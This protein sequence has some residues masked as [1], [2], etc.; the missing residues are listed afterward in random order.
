MS[1][2]D[3][4]LTVIYNNIDECSEDLATLRDDS[5]DSEDVRHMTDAIQHLRQALHDL[6]MV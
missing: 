1:D 3:N 2:F 4:D 6:E 5:R